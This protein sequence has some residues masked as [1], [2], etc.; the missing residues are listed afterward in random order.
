VP[1][2]AAAAIAYFARAP[3]IVVVLV[4]VAVFAAALVPL[5]RAWRRAGH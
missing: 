5:R 3:W 1:A 2:V 4:A